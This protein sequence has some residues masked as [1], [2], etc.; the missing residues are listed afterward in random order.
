MSDS[1]SDSFDEESILIANHAHSHESSNIRKINSLGFIRE[2]GLADKPLSLT[3]Q[4]DQM[5]QTM[6][7][8]V[9]FNEMD[10]E[11]LQTRDMANRDI[12]MMISGNIHDRQV[13]VRTTSKSRLAPIQDPETLSA[14]ELRRQANRL[15][16]QRRRMNE[17]AEAKARRLA[18]E[19]QARRIS[20]ANG[21]Y[22]AMPK[23]STVLT[24]VDIFDHRV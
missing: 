9:S 12:N 15:I 1:D 16:Q 19:A 21:I 22:R 6:H 4:G 23:T 14:I 3:E 10:Q 11:H 13:E 17:T 20:R 2:N 8:M 18:N 7:N 24:F 5:R